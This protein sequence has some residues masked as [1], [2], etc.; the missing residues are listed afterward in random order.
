MF[1]VPLIVILVVAALAYGGY[2][3]Y[4]RSRAKREAY[5]PGNILLN[6]ANEHD[7]NGRYGQAIRSYKNA[8]TYFRSKNDTKN[9]ARTILMQALSHQAANEHEKAVD[10]FM[11]AAEMCREMGDKESLG[12]VYMKLSE[13]YEIQEIYPKAEKYQ[14][15]AKDIWRL[16]D[17][18]P[19]SKYALYR[20]GL[21]RA[22]MGRKEAAVQDLEEAVEYHSKTLGLP[23]LVDMLIETAGVE[24]GLGARAEA[25]RNYRETERNLYRLG[26]TKR[27]A[28]TRK[29]I[30]A[31]EHELPQD[32]ER[33]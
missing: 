21:T 4:H 6:E 25:L 22:K 13:T 3:A 24:E 7:R 29:K 27:G 14:E 8:E 31:L 33:P 26:D 32:Q 19:L 5:D 10:V 9:T 18:E 1:L 17:N 30:E 15:K 11:E 16:S 12:H 2:Q 28:E 20:L 23:K